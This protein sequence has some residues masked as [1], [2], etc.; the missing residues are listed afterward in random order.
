MALP[1]LEVSVD[2]VIELKVVVVITERIDEALGYFKPTK[3]EDELDDGEERKV[4]ILPVVVTTQI[5]SSN[6][7]FLHWK[8]GPIFVQVPSGVEELPGILPF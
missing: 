6:C 7:S 1:D 2:D 5:E 8:Q 3:V 4:E